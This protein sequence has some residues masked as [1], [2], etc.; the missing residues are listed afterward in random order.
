MKYW[1]QLGWLKVTAVSIKTS[2]IG[3]RQFPLRSLHKEYLNNLNLGHLQQLLLSWSIPD[4]SW[5]R[6]SIKQCHSHC[7]ISLM[8]LDWVWGSPPSG[9]WRCQLFWWSP[10]TV[11]SGSV[12]GY[13]PQN[14]TGEFLS[15]AKVHTTKYILWHK[16]LLVL[17]YILNKHQCSGMV[18][19]SHLYVNSHLNSGLREKSPRMYCF[20]SKII[21]DHLYPLG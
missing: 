5:F 7:Q 4:F 15:L 11:R 20:H 14:R 8:P 18:G 10:S 6:T 2:D 1:L 3:L 13:Q 19:M 16:S 12:K 9:W 21:T 17:S